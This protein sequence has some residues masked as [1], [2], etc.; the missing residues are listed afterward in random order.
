MSSRPA[1]AAQ[2]I[3]GKPRL[4]KTLFGETERESERERERE[5]QR[6]RDIETQTEQDRQTENHKNQ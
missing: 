6:H 3:P 4:Q 1:Q 5:S 2:I